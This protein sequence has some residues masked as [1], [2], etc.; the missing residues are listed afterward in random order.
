MT[1]IN[2]NPSGGGGS[3]GFGGDVGDITITEK[4]NIP[5][6]TYQLT[7]EEQIKDG[8][9]TPELFAK[10]GYAGSAGLT[11]V[12]YNNTTNTADTCDGVIAINKESGITYIISKGNDREG[13]LYKNT[14]NLT[15]ISTSVNLGQI[16]SADFSFNHS[17]VCFK[18]DDLYIYYSSSSNC[19][20]RVFDTT[21]DTWKTSQTLVIGISEIFGVHYNSNINKVVICLDFNNNDYWL[22]TS[23]G[24]THTVF[25]S[26]NYYA[27]A[28]SDIEYLNTNRD[29]NNFYY[30]G[31]YWLYNY[32]NQIV[33]K[34]DETNFSGSIVEDLTK[35]LP[36]FSGNRLQCT[37]NGVFW[38]IIGRDSSNPNI[39]I[40]YSDDGFLTHETRVIPTPT[41]TSLSVEMFL[42]DN[43]SVAGYCNNIFYIN[44]DLTQDSFSTVY[45]P[46]VTAAVSSNKTIFKDGDYL[47][48][49]TSNGTSNDGIFNYNFNATFSDMPLV[50]PVSP[51]TDKRYTYNVRHTT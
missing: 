48:F 14:N 33:Y 30:G 35:T 22:T 26:N 4:G 39:E 29:G 9:L 43:V 50:L 7:N 47:N 10:E 2:T 34:V 51:S 15:D 32:Q 31:F 18:G 44:Y 5:E 16:A 25:G 13:I 45:S 6:K 11:N 1:I 20:C 49:I 38:F 37:E 42:I 12:T 17:K 28:G 8:S 27:S 24:T 19:Y 36:A 21:S 46:I 3:G 23:D 41:G 40:C